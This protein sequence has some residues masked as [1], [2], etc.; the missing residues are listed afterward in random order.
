MTGSRS[1]R[2]GARAGVLSALIAAGVMASTQDADAQVRF[3]FRGELG[4]GAMLSDWQRQSLR[5]DSVGFQG[6]GRLF[7]API[8][9]LSV[10]LSVSNWLFLNATPSGDI[11]HVLGLTGGLRFEPMLGRVGRLF[12]DGNA[13]VGFTGP[14]T[15]FHFDAGLGFEF[16]LHRYFAIGPVVRY[17]H[18]LQ[19]DEESAPSDAMWLAGGLSFTIGTPRAE[20]EAPPADTDSDGVV[21]RD[22]QCV[23]E[24]QGAN[25]DPSRPGCPDGDA[26][27]DG[28]RNSTDQCRDVA[29]GPTPD[30]ARPGCPI[31]DTDRDGVL[32]SEDQCV[33]EAQGEHPDPARRGCPDGDADNDGVLNSADQCRDVPAGPHPD[34]ARAGCP[35]S[36]RDRDSVADAVD[37]CPD[38]PGAPSTDPN[39]NGCP[40]QVVFSGNTIQINTP[41]FF[42]HNRDTIL[43]RSFPILQAVGD[44]LRAS[45]DVR[46]V[47]VEG[48]T[49][50]VG[51]D[52]ENMALSERRA[53]S[54]VRWLSEHGVEASRLEGHGFGESRP[55]EPITAG[56]ARRARR[57]AQARNRRVDF[58][59]V[60]PAAAPASTPA[61]K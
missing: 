21:D 32:D 38:Q 57:N 28:V 56:M 8:D 61:P 59:I 3:G 2:A 12:I 60:D 35:T 16:Q 42:A 30:P 55:L 13:G 5:F 37:H 23:S 26:D 22:D 4:A 19:P 52:Q 44:A 9:W 49:D 48:H 20:A 29:Q 7:V 6:T 43:P 27:S 40:G 45:P 11:G 18:V 1:K 25:P 54:V 39:R 24:P 50:D 10:Q 41:V 51:G 58:R 34:P 14:L 53:Q 47:S 33:N 15:R 17:G 36:D 31:A 46:R